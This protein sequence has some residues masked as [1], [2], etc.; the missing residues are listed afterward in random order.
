MGQE[1]ENPGLG[2]YYGSFMNGALGEIMKYI[3]VFQPSGA[4]GSC[5]NSFQMN[6]YSGCPCPHPLGA[7]LARVHKIFR[8]NF[9]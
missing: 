9:E 7:A 8:K 4:S 2:I 1:M 6:L 5:S 3:P